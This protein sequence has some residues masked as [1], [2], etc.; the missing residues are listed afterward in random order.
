MF[1]SAEEAARRKIDADPA[2]YH[3]DCKWAAGYERAKAEDR[4]IEQIAYER[5][6]A[7]TRERM[8]AWGP[9]VLST[10]P[11][12]AEVVAA[13]L[14]EVICE[15]EALRAHRVAAVEEIIEESIVLR[16]RYDNSG[17]DP[18]AQLSWML[19]NARIEAYW[20]ILSEVMGENDD[21]TG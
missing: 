12:D 19:W 1:A 14:V 4:N 21:P 17:K 7:D 11:G 18:N 13:R 15:Q 6:V 10:K 3:V 16:D 5:G 2:M 20:D 8:A 9:T